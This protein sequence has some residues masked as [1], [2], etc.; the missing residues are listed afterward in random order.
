MRASLGPGAAEWRGVQWRG[1]GAQR[2]VA[3]MALARGALRGTR[4][5][6]RNG[7]YKICPRTPAVAPCVRGGRA[8]G[9]GAGHVVRCELRRRAHRQRWRT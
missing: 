7:T 5:V 8:R 1:V 9:A 6:R 4:R 3:G 2:G